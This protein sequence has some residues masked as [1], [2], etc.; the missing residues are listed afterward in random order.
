L[1][2]SF[3]EQETDHSHQDMMKVDKICIQQIQVSTSKF[4][5]MEIRMLL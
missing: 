2:G 5:W 3:Y 4:I 1:H